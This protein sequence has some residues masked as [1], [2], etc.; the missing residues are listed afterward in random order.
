MPK[1]TITTPIY[2]INDKPHIGHAYATIIS[3]TLARYH[4]LKGDDVF[5]LTGTDENSLKNVE[6]AEK[7]GYGEK[8]TEYLDLQSAV[9][10]KTW[11]DLAI[12]NT[13]FIRTT[14]E[15]H[16]KGVEKFFDLVN[17][18]GDIYKGTYHGWYCKGCE[19]FVRES[20]LIDGL[21][22]FHKTKPDAI[23]EENYF[24]RASK[25]RDALL[26][27]IEANPGFIQ[28]VNR[29]NEIVN[30]I[31][32]HFEDVSISRANVS[33]GIPLPIDPKH[34]VYVW[35]D[36]LI[37][38][39]TGI[40]YG[41]DEALFEK[42]WPADVHIV[43]KDIIKFH[44]A[45]WPAMLLSAGLPLPKKV[46]AHGFFT[47]NGERIGKSMGNAIDPLELERQYGLDPLRY[48]LLAEI[49]F[50]GDGDFSF[51]RVKER[52]ESDLS[53]GLGNF[54]S[55]VTTLSAK[56]T[57]EDFSKGLE[58]ESAEKIKIMLEETWERWEKGFEEYRLDESLAAIWALLRF[59]DKHIEERKPWVL[60]KENPAEFAACL[61][62][63][64]EVVR[65][66]S[67]LIKPIL[68]A[69]SEKI[70]L[71]LGVSQFHSDNLLEVTKR[72]GSVT[73]VKVVKAEALFPPLQ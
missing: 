4:R 71:L 11:K 63:L 47:I 12:T 62:A 16:H 61:V 8:L 46:F 57:K 13:D 33:C 9:W 23:E 69:T 42:W 26:A 32:D 2:Y 73:L 25:Y 35:F 19:A 10:Q 70:E 44:C 72:F 66:L 56:L 65:H 64:S 15:R 24:F 18:K 39:L 37:N 48:F 7:A 21:C 36:A 29:R 52:Y 67:L 43:G 34:V 20:D 51:D 40:G 5:F 22:P 55:R 60:A 50:G 3:D 27:H 54:V 30:Y 14:E 45:L 6:A 41:W 31:K 53:K 17:G 38:Y 49:P 59:G 28:P 1:Y 58:G 68:P